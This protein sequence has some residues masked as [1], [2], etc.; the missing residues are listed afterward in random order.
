MFISEDSQDSNTLIFFGFTKTLHNL[1]VKYRSPDWPIPSLISMSFNKVCYRECRNAARW[2]LNNIQAILRW[3]HKLE[4]ISHI[5]NIS[6]YG[7]I[8]WHW[9]SYT[10]A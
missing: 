7:Q 6:E 2:R 8:M 5:S 10:E 9:M 3:K 1:S 4:S